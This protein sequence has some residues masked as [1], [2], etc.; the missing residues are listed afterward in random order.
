MKLQLKDKINLNNF[1][2]FFLG[3]F[4]EIIIAKYRLKNKATN[5]KIRDLI[6]LN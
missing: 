4:I 5:K 6:S 1:T 3:I 2:E